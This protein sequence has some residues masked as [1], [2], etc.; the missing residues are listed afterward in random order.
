[1]CRRPSSPMAIRLERWAHPS[2]PL[3]QSRR[4][5]PSPRS[6]AGHRS[7]PV[8][9]IA[10]PWWAIY[11]A[12]IRV[13]LFGPGGWQLDPSSGTPVGSAAW[14]GQGQ[15]SA[16]T[17]PSGPVSSYGAGRFDAP[18]TAAWDIL[19]HSYNGGTPTGT[20]AIPCSPSQQMA[21]SLYVKSNGLA[22]SASLSL[23]LREFD[24]SGSLLRSSTLA[25]LSG[26]QSSWTQ[27]AGTATTGAICAYV[28]LALRALD[29]TSASANGT[30]WL[31]NAQLWNKTQLREA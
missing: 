15:S 24:A 27:L 28:D 23:V 9:R 7:R 26:N 3:G 31:D 10:H 5:M 6:Q 25:T 4:R 29:A 8:G 20:W 2:S 11:A 14:E 12:C 16:N 21:G 19:F 30:I 1:M 22:G 13:S 18:P 17:Y